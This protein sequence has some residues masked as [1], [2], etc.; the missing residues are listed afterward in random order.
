VGYADSKNKTA[1]L[2]NIS[3]IQEFADVFPEDVLS[4]VKYF[5]DHTNSAE[6]WSTWRNIDSRND[7][8][9]KTKTEALMKMLKQR[10]ILLTGGQDQ[11]RWGNNNE[12][13]FNPKEAKGILLE[14]DSHVLDRIWQNL[15]KHQGW[16]KIKLF[17]W[18]VHHKKILT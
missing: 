11:L 14:M 16:M 8:P 13:T 18:L 17:M 15:W 3:V 6:K 12:G 2:D 7:S 10:K 4:K 5:W 9:L 1:T